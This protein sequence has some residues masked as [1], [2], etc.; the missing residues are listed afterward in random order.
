M[1]HDWEY[2]FWLF[3]FCRISSMLEHQWM[4]C[5]HKFTNW[6]HEGINTP[7]VIHFA[8]MFGFKTCQFLDPVSHRC[9]KKCNAST[10]P[11]IEFTKVFTLPSSYI[12]HEYLDFGL[13]VSC[14][15]ITHRFANHWVQKGFG[16]AFVPS[17]ISHDYFELHTS[18]IH[19]LPFFLI[20]EMKFLSESVPN[21][22]IVKFDKIVWCCFKCAVC[23]EWPG[24]VEAQDSPR[25]PSFTKP[26]H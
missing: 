20:S 24:K 22:W 18:N 26:H 11:V 3:G 19:C 15:S 23:S 2:L 17:C 7:F 5:L 12:S 21:S 9:E 10:I 4:Q 16:T 25:L 14:S 1:R 13:L 8:W 6:V